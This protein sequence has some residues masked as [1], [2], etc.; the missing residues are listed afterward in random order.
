VLLFIK[1]LLFT[2]FVPGTVAVFVPL[3]V[4]GH[5]DPKFSPGSVFSIGLLVLG[6]S[7]YI[8]CLWDFMMSGRG[9]PAPI[10]PP[11]SL[12]VRGLYR[13]TRNPMYVG[14]L[15]VIAGWALLFQSVDLFLYGVCVAASFKFFVVFYEERYL[16]REFGASYKEYCA[17]VHRWW[18]FP[19]R[20]AR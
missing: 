18:P 14:V 1:N 8:W 5:P 2:L 11:K 20:P 6:G 10:D 3:Y 13:Y 7:I 17:R 12:V 16:Q 4:F 9:T 19:K 15:C